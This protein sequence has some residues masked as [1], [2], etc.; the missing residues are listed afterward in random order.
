MSPLPFA[1]LALTFSMLLPL[2]VV[3]VLVPTACTNDLGTGSRVL[4]DLQSHYPITVGRLVTA[5]LDPVR[6]LRVYL[7]ICQDGD[8]GGPVCSESDLRLLAMVE[9]GHKSLL[10]RLAER[11]LLEGRE[12]PVYVYGPMCDG[13][14][15][16]ILVPRCQTA[17]ALGI[18]DPNLK[19]YVIYSTT[20]GDGVLESEGFERFIEVTGRA[21]GIARKA[22]KLVN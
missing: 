20:H 8:E 6:R 18:W 9:S 1:P 12:M 5:Q 22:A 17:V 15:E 3:V 19:D 21:S 4:Q 10:E 14:E 7:Q 2:L 11:Y 16:M 13:L